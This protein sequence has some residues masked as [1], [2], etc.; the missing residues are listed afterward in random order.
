VNEGSEVVLKISK[1]NLKLVPDV[2]SQGFTEN[3]AKAALRSNGFNNIEVVRVAT[4]NPD[5]NGIVT[6]QAPAANTP[7]DPKS[8]V[9]IFVGDYDEPPP[10]TTPPASPPPGG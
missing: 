2:S 8:K 7:K 6:D 3:E 4:R 1:G 10:T 9:Q 5:E